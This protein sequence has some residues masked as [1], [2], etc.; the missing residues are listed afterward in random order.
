[1]LRHSS[2]ISEYPNFVGRALDSGWKASI[3][4]ELGRIYANTR[5]VE[6]SSDLDTITARHVPTWQIGG[7]HV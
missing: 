2:S 6:T 1:M 5:L 7:G 4:S 3:S